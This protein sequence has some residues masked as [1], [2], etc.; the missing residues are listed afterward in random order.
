MPANLKRRYQTWYA[1]LTIPKEVRGQFDGKAEFVESLKTDSL[2]EAQRLVGP[3]LGRWR[4]WIEEARSTDPDRRYL[5]SVQRALDDA[6][7]RGDEEAEFAIKGS[8]QER[9][10]QLERVHGYETARRWYDR[11]SGQRTDIAQRA[12][13]WLADNQYETKS[14]TMHRQ[15]IRLLVDF[16]PVAEN[17]DR[18]TAARFVSEVLKPNRSAATV[19]KMISTYSQLWRWLA[20]RGYIDEP[21]VWSRQQPRK[22]HRQGRKRAADFKPTRRPFTDDEAR[23]MFAAVDAHADKHPTDPLAVRLMAVT[24][25][26]LNEVCSLRTGNVSIDD[27]DPGCVWLYVDEGKTRSAIRLA[28]VVDETTVAMLRERLKDRAEDKAPWFFPEYTPKNKLGSRSAP[29]SQRLR[30]YRDDHIGADP[31]VVG[32]HSW[33]HRARTAVEQA[34][35]RTS[36][37]N[38]FF[39]HNLDTPSSSAAAISC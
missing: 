8:A 17:I 7:R 21:T 6:Q 12:E 38:A 10:E 28:P 9:A 20:D 16:E 14:V 33:R 29:L 2:R 27:E 1:R 39:G 23:A 3:V 13:D 30:R 11:A 15:A 18:R 37:V 25:M 35:L 34:D 26:R 5:R 4:T 31:T 36:L 19:T 24:G 22:S 32:G